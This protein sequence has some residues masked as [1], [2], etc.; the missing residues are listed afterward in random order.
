MRRSRYVPLAIAIGMAI[1]SACDRSPAGTPD[2]VPLDGPTLLAACKVA[3]ASSVTGTIGPAGGV[4]SLGGASLLVPAGAL[5]TDTRFEVTVPSSPFAEVEIR[6]DGHDHFRFQAPVVIAIDYSECNATA[7]AKLT[8]WHID[9]DTKQLLE[10]MGGVD[11]KV[12]RRVMFSTMHLSGYAI[13][14]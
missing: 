6:A 4:L 2:Y 13:A 8:A 14:N 9:P 3:P 11:D 10:N 7:T 1:T 5:L 12:A